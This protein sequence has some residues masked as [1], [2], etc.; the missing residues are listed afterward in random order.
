MPKENTTDKTAIAEWNSARE[1]HV[2][3]SRALDDKWRK[4]QE[5]LLDKVIAECD[6]AI[7]AVMDIVNTIPTERDKE[8]FK[9]KSVKRFRERFSLT[10]KATTNATTSVSAGTS[11]KVVKD[12]QILE[13]LATGEKSSK[14]LQEQFGWTTSASVGQR[15]K[16]LEDAGKVTMR[17]GKGTGRP[18]FYSLKK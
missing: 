11:T 7:G 13:F 16:A 17:R 5:K 18:K 6:S 12:E 8:L 10:A 1:E 4:A 2:R 14:E 15:M 3:E 9:L